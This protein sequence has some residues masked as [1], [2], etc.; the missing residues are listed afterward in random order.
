MKKLLFLLLLLLSNVWTIHS[1]PKYSLHSYLCFNSFYYSPLAQNNSSIPTYKL[2]FQRFSSQASIEH[3]LSVHRHLTFSL[4]YS[5]TFFSIL[6]QKL[7]HYAKEETHNQTVAS[8]PPISSFAQ[9]NIELNLKHKTSIISG[10]GVFRTS[11]IS[12]VNL[13]NESPSIDK[14]MNFQPANYYPYFMVGIEKNCTIFNREMVYSLQYHIGFM[15]FTCSP[16]EKG[17]VA[18]RSYFQG[19]SIGIK[20]KY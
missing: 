10:G 2:G 15:P 14:R 4:Q 3:K 7:Q 20:Y 9:T 5:L 8:A 13:M 11:P 12:K 1:S 6:Q 18:E 16:L 19:L 17:P